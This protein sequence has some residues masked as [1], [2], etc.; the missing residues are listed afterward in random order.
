MSA[1]DDALHE[2]YGFLDGE[3]TDEK[4]KQISRHIDDCGSCL[5]VFDF[6][7]ELRHVVQRKCQEQVPSSLKARIAEAI[8]QVD[9][10]G[11][12]EPGALPPD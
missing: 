2:L 9:S 12:V 11:S 4:R 8:R 5:E 6:E 3:L 7:V 1:C 10:T